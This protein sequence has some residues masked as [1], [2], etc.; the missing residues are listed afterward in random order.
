MGLLMQSFTQQVF[1]NLSVAFILG[2]GH[3]LVNK[4]FTL[5]AWIIYN[6][7]S[8]ADLASSGLFPI[9]CHVL[10][11]TKPFPALGGFPWLVGGNSC[12]R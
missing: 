2:S 11:V 8:K 12:F 9:K 6:V 7:V 3:V 10:T 4:R 1:V 5:C